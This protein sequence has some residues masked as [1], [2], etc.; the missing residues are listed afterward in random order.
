MK[1][2]RIIR[3]ILFALFAV[4]CIVV[5]YFD[6]RYGSWDNKA[7]YIAFIIGV[8]LCLP[9]IIKDIASPY[10]GKRESKK[11][12]R[13]RLLFGVITSAVLSIGIYL[14]LGLNPESLA[15]LESQ[16]GVEGVSIPLIFFGIIMAINLIIELLLFYLP[17]RLG[18]DDEPQSEEEES[19]NNISALIITAVVVL[20]V[21]A[22]V[23][24]AKLVPGLYDYINSDILILIVVLVVAFGIYLFTHKRS[25]E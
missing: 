25:A 17:R 2:W 7:M 23:L 6:S 16:M 14:L 11:F 13:R 21:L 24:V 12:L 5:G 1:A 18:W 20:L 3:A 10:K 4:V 9:R 19:R 8:I 15:V 22:S